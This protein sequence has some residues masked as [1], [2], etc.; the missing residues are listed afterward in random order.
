MLTERLSS[1]VLSAVV[2]RPR[3]AVHLQTWA[4][5]EHTSHNFC[6][7][8]FAAPKSVD[9][10]HFWLACL[11][12]LDE[13]EMVEDAE[14]LR[15]LI[16]RCRPQH[17]D[18]AKAAAVAETVCRGHLPQARDTMGAVTAC[19]RLTMSWNLDGLYARNQTTQ[20]AWFWHTSE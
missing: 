1:T 14:E 9:I 5:R 16:E 8:G 13:R 10:E 4:Y 15:A 20:Y 3:P 12:A 18:P 6:V 17:V 19:A 11:E 2:S 7:E